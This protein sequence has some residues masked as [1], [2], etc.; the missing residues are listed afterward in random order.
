VDSDQKYVN[1]E[2]IV[3]SMMKK[4]GDSVYSV[5]AQYITD[6]TFAGGT[7]WEADMSTG[8]VGLGFGDDTMPQQVTPELKAELEELAAK[9]IAGEIV[10]ES[11]R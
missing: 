9:I 4:V 3:T 11:T 8:L 7:I 6:G 1:P 2:V 10:V 5:I